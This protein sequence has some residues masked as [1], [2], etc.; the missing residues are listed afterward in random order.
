MKQIYLIISM[1][2]LAFLPTT[3]IADV[4]SE[5]DSA[6]A[7]EQYAEAIKLYEQAPASAAVYYNIGNCH[8]RL[9]N[10]AH[11][12]LF[13]ERAYLLSPGNDDIR[14]NL[15]MA[16]GKTV[17]KLV[18]RHEFFF[19]SW[20]RSLCNIMSVDAWAYLA[21]FSL[22]FALVSL[23]LYVFLPLGRIRTSSM[24]LGVLLLL[25]C[26]FS[27]LFAFS[28]RYDLTHRTGAIIMTNNGNVKST[29]SDTGKDLFVLHEGT[30][31]EITDDT[32]QGWLEVELS[33]G[34]KG[35][36]ERKHVEVI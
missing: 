31:V 14:F 8:Y 15:S 21:V 16:R 33:D 35:W 18:P 34:K 9:N 19:V 2:L 29:P 4:R 5:A 7:R 32:L 6:Y 12:I 3:V 26:A 11:A 36:I 24:L 10:L 17:D 23:L 25:V 22:I 28:Q 27:N 1:T 20:Y 13:Y 30:R